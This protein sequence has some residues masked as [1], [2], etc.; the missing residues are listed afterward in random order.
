MN[1]DQAL[2]MN[3]RLLDCYLEA[4]LELLPD[5]IREKCRG[6]GCYDDG[7]DHPSQTR[8]DVCMMMN[9][10]QQVETAWCRLANS[11]NH[12]MVRMNYDPLNYISTREV[13]PTHHRRFLYTNRDDAALFFIHH[14]ALLKMILTKLHSIHQ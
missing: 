4:L 11:I 1:P 9:R 14:E 6:C 13:A 5:A 2:T 7:Q 8:H 10:K 12:E 3:P